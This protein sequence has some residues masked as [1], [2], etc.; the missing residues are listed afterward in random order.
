M[1]L[2]NIKL[3]KSG[4]A[5]IGRRELREV[6]RE[7]IR[8][9]A[10][11]WIKK[12]LPLHFKATARFR[13]DYA[14]RPAKYRKRKR[15]R[16]WIGDSRAIGEDLPLVWSGRTRESALNNNRIEAI[17]KNYK[18]Y[19]SEVIMPTPALNFQ[20][21]LR[22][23]LTALSSVEIRMLQRE[24]G[25]EYERQLNKRGRTKKTTKTYRAAA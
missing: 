10:A 8:A 18:L 13:Y 7:S 6:G 23:E 20:P 3:T 25:E 21:E 5:G 16:E 14:F 11:L 4:V 24:F 12:Y 22:D 1:G 17:A 15:N 9:A 2:I 19:R